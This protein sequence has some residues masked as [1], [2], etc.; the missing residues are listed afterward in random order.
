MEGFMQRQISFVVLVLFIG[1][2]TIDFAPA[3]WSA[4][5]IDDTTTKSGITPVIGDGNAMKFKNEL[6]RRAYALF[7]LIE[8]TD[9]DGAEKTY[10]QIYCR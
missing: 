8:A 3:A 4:I 7:Y 1:I 5:L 9:G 2:S 10:S 6:R